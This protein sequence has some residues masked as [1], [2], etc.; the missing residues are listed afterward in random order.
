MASP[1]PWAVAPRAR[2]ERSSDEWLYGA[3]GGSHLAA[4]PGRITRGEWCPIEGHEATR[5]RGR[6]PR[7][8]G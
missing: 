2:R 7:A 8:R 6:P 4:A 1:D 3:E 5:N